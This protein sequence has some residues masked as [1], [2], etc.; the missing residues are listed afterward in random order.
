M[1]GL[2]IFVPELYASVATRLRGLFEGQHPLFIQERQR[3]LSHSRP[4]DFRVSR[5]T[6]SSPK[7]QVRWARAVIG[8]KISPIDENE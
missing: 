4:E 5:S 1:I 3:V 2:A 8:P 7:G 6:S